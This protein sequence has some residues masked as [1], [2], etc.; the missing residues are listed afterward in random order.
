[1]SDNPFQALVTAMEPSGIP[2]Q[3]LVLGTVTSAAP[4]KVLVGG[5][6]QERAD[7][8]CNTDLVDGTEAEVV[9]RLTGAGSIAGST[10]SISGAA[11]FTLS[12][13][14]ARRDVFKR[15]DRLLLLPIEDNQRYIILCKVVDL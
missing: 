13:K 15:G 11:D 4:L 14:L 9:T 1:M 10:S 2:A 5:N 6:T 12:G 7:L 8:M 3:G